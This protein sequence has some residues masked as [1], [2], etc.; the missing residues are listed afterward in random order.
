MH[1]ENKEYYIPSFLKSTPIA[2]VLLAVLYFA[3]AWGG[4]YFR[5]GPTDVSPIF[6]SI[7]LALAAVLIY[8]YRV[9]LGVWLGSFFVNLWSFSSV[10]HTFDFTLF[11][12]IIPGTITALGNVLGIASAVYLI[13]RF[14]KNEYPLYSGKNVL[15]FLSI[16]VFVCCLIN[17]SIGVLVLTITHEVS[18][19]EM[20]YV[21]LT[22]WLGDSIGLITLAPFILSWLHKSS[23]GKRL[24]PWWELS[25]LL[26]GVLLLSYFIY[27]HYPS[28]LYLLF[29]LLLIS[30][31][32]FGMRV[33]TAVVLVIATFSAINT[34]PNIAPFRAENVNNSILQMDIFITVIT[35]SSLAFAGM[36]AVKRRMTESLRINEE[37]YR[38]IFENMQ[39]VFYQ[40]KLDGT[41]M[42]LSPSVFDL[43][44]LDRT[45]MIGTSVLDYQDD[46]TMIKQFLAVLLKEHKASDYELK[47]NHGKF[48]PLYISVNG[49]MI[50]DKEG[51]P[52][53]IDGVI[54]NITERKLKDFKIA[55][56]NTIL[57]AQN[58]EL[59]Q[60]AYITSH[61]LQEPLLTLKC[62]SDLL[63]E[64]CNEN[65]S[66]EA[67][68]Y[69]EFIIQSSNR[70]QTLV[71]GL[72]FYSRIGKEREL[73]P[74]DCNAVLMEVIQD[75]DASINKNKA[76]ISTVALPVING[77]AVEIRQL[78]QNL[79]SNSLKF[80]K[81]NITP[82]INIS[83]QEEETNWLFSFQDNGIGIDKK[84]FDKVFIIFKRLHDRA[85]YEGTGIGLSYCKKIVELHGGKIWIESTLGEGTS[86]K[87]RIP[88]IV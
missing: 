7:G 54:R 12:D 1:S 66:K 86:F 43:F 63:L 79:I 10:T 85:D 32:H 52:T 68:K 39:D 37:K 18:F 59:E 44:Q 83:V 72:L 26:V 53:H 41:I 46:S 24:R 57:Q 21:W 35:F 3:I 11:Q 25:G 87:F 8:G 60:F 48:G 30:A 80:K 38:S 88:K 33:N 50:Y 81:Q 9:L 19:E 34:N 40:I 36:V 22:W 84:D 27:Y 49:R 23:S 55:E 45:K 58:K 14:C 64:E 71:K 28:Y 67:K 56:Q 15:G 65:V 77:D 70:M 20:K 6:P 75:M 16:G 73:V 13:K 29:P 4:I 2:I 82:I 74:I 17:S 69:L 42:E 31:Y 5:I 76:Q 61:D 51:K 47:L 62:F 78:F